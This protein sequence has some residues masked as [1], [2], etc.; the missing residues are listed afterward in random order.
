MATIAAMTIADA[1]GTPV[2]H[3]FVP[4]G[5]DSKGVMLWQDQTSADNPSGVPDGFT[6]M[7]A[8]S[9]LQTGKAGSG[10][11]ALDFRFLKPTLETVSNSTASGILPAAQKAYD[12]AVFIKCVFSA[13]STLQNRKDAV[14]MAVLGFQ[15]AQLNDWAT[16]YQRPY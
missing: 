2:N 5:F 15:N 11:F 10:R 9:V 14:K 7:L 4:I 13:R 6:N 16:L 12:S 8:S 1:L 3:T